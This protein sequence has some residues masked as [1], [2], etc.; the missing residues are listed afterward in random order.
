MRAAIG[1]PI[2]PVDVGFFAKL[3][4]LTAKSQL[5]FYTPFAR[6]SFDRVVH[7][8]KNTAI[9][10]EFSSSANACCDDGAEVYC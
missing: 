7:I 6:C 1:K 5:N 9:M 8:E 2:N 10:N 4:I 3:P